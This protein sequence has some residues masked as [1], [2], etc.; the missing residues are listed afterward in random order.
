MATS[1]SVDFQHTRTQVIE[2]ALRKCSVLREGV[3]AS[4]NQLTTGALAL[5]GI[6]KALA[7]DGMP[8]W[9]IRQ[10]SV[11]PIE[12]VNTVVL[13][14]SG[15]HAATT[16]V[17]TEL[18]AAVASGASTITVDSITGM[19]SGDSIGIEMDDGTVHWTTINGAPS[20]STVTLTTATDAA[21]S[22]DNQ[23]Y[24]YTTKTVRPLKIIQAQRYDYSTDTEVPIN[25]V[26]RDEFVRL[27]NKTT[28]G[29]PHTIWL[30]HGVLTSTLNF[31][32][33]FD[34]GKQTIRIW[35]QRPFEDMDNATDNLD[36]PQEY[37]QLIILQL[38][39][40]LGLENSVPQRKLSMIGQL[41]ELER[42]RVGAF[43]QEEGSV[44][45]TPNRTGR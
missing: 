37:E 44:Y 3:S 23:V 9:A 24:T 12:D 20:G 1:G 45:F 8:L 43:G 21:A 16:F 2:S 30:D 38:A 29:P 40:I 5:N 7:V 31:Y 42:Q 14:P 4:A 35:F 25:I 19:T 33:R 6:V 18:S 28:E 34:N 13:G 22:V 27:S 36:F 11:F 10:S 26:S 32:P 39:L 15:G 41:A 17:N